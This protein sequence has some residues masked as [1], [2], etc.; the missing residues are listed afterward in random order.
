MTKD[1]LNQRLELLIAEYNSGDGAT[2]RVEK[3]ILSEVDSTPPQPVVFEF[4]S[5][6]GLAGSEKMS[7]RKELRHEAWV[8]FDRHAE[9]RLKTFN[10]YLLLVGAIIAGFISAKDKLPVTWPILALLA[11]VTFIFYKLDVR[12][13]QL[14]KHSEEALK[15]LEDLLPLPDNRDGSPHR[16]KLFRH[17]QYESEQLKKLTQGRLIPARFSYTTCFNWLFAL[18]GYGGAMLSA[19]LLYLW[20]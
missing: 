3:A 2:T 5:A 9:Q 4:V 8:Y 16:C 15:I 12:N 14:T 1:E 13:R 10:F 19:V 17:E 20:K 6:S 18:F 7:L 11:P